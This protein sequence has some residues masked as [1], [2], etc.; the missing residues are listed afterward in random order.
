MSE[1]KVTANQKKSTKENIVYNKVKQ[2][3]NISDKTQLKN[4]TFR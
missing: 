1:M 4:M 2:N 3:F